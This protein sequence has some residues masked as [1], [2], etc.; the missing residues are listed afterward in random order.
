MVTRERSNLDLCRVAFLEPDLR[1]L[2]PSLNQFI[3]Y[4]F[5]HILSR[6]APRR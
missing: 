1:N 5:W 4:A 6:D 3:Q 2:K